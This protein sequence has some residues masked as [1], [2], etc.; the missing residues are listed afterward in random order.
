MVKLFRRLPINDVVAAFTI[1]AKLPFVH[2]FVASYTLLREPDVSLGQIFLFQER[3]EFRRDMRGSVAFFACDRGV[4]TLEWVAGQFVIE[5]FFRFF[6][7]DQR[8]IGAVVLEVTADTFAAVGV[9]HSQPCM[10]AVIIGEYFCNFFVTV[11]AFES[12]RFCAELMAT[13]ALG[14]TRKGLMSFGKW[15]RRDLGE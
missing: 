2:V 3:A 6:P 13:G 7:M 14:R 8:K 12:R 1:F 10:V 9:L 5:V 11:E 4:L 15:T